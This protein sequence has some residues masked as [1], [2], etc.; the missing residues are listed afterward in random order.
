MTD[1]NH[2]S[3]YIG[4]MSGT[5]LDG[6]DVVLMRFTSQG[7][8]VAAAQTYPYPP[9][10]ADDLLAL[11]AAGTDEIT[12]MMSA[13]IRLA[14]FT[15]QS[16]LDLLQQQDLPPEAITAIGHHGQTIRHLP[17]SDTPGT[18]QIGDANTL[19]QLTGITTVADFRRRD[20]A[21]GG[22]G[23]PLVP[24]FHRATFHDPDENRVIVN[25]GGIANITLLSTDGSDVIGFDSGPGN[26]LMDL[27]YRLHQSGT[28]DVD[29]RWAESGVVHE[30][31]LAAMLAD[32]YFARP[33][34]KSSGREYFHQTWLTQLLSG[35]E[36]SAADVQATLCQLT[37]ASILHAIQQTGRSCERIL[38]CGG[39]VHNLSLMRRLK[40]L[41]T[42]LPLGSTAEYGIHPD[43]VEGACF[44]WLAQQ[45]LA[46]RP[47]NLPAVTGASHEVILGAIY[48][49]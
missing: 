32:P 13:D 29:G 7:S 5:S 42:P 4:T 44:A 23:A 9:H 31:L 19:A 16:V 45:T 18:L 43:W 37:A 39:G 14:R 17:T 48:Q 33:Y 27:W 28:I 30:P 46:A 8:V 10:L 26:V 34:P 3:Y 41:V 49:A 11:C 40:Q 24:A 25:I 15:A 6:L 2:H 36:L 20:M 12:R 38:I 47:A 22:Q 35:F 21:A 1:T